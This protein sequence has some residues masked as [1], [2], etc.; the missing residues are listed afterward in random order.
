MIETNLS[1]PPIIFL[2][3]QPEEQ[4]AMAHSDSSV[5]DL[6]VIV[7]ANP[8]LKLTPYRLDTLDTASR[9]DIV[10]YKM[11]Y[12]SGNLQD[13]TGLL[14]YPHT[15]K[16][17]DG[18]R[19][20]VWT[21]GTVGVG[22]ACA[23]SNNSINQNFKITA[24]ALLQAGYVIFAPDYE[25]LGTPGIH[26]YLHLKSE[27]LSAIYGVVAIKHYFQADYEGSWMVIGQ[28]Q[29]G[30]ASLGTAEY[31]NHDPLFKGAVAGAPASGLLEIIRDVMPQQLTA[32]NQF[33]AENFIPLAERNAVRSYATILAYGALVGIGIKAENP[34]FDYLSLFYP[35]ARAFA[36]SAEG[37]NGEDGI[38]LHGVRDLFHADLVSFMT[39][40]P[41]K[42][43]MEY[44]G[45]DIEA[46][47][48]HPVL[49]SFFAKN[50][51][52]TKKL[53]KPV[54][55]IQ[56]TEDTNVPAV[57]TEALVN[58]LRALGSPS[59]EF[60]LVEGASHT[61]AILW[62]NAELLQFIQNHM[63]AR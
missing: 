61:E 55:I 38:C 46:F 58:N 26:P 45:I 18:W 34:D 33:E 49:L 56:G 21:H 35:N 41:D 31:A 8:T 13:A 24:D 63:P 36:K 12:L 42:S 44:P 60:L 14:F 54:L 4:V 47:Q 53:D 27:A 51:P 29:G 23:P 15:E 59:I 48:S 22:D 19:I 9:I 32:L 50:Q 20:V 39:E 16:P 17:H 1:G 28:S 37:T 10:T 52:G 7:A 11:P 62:K 2:D 30:Q 6:D 5:F 25:G 3:F 57:V 43:L 40:H